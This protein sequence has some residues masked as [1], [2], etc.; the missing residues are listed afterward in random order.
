[1]FSAVQAFKALSDE[2]RL[3]LLNVLSR[4]ELN[5]NE[6]V[7]LMGMG[8]SRVSRHLKILSEAGLVGWRRD[9]LWIF[10]SAVRDG[11]G[12]DFTAAALPFVA[13]EEAF[14]ADLAL[15]AGIIEERTASTRHFFNRIAEDWDQLA[16]EVLGDFSLPEAVEKA[17]PACAV[18]ADL[19][20]GTGAVLERMLG[21]A[22]NV[23]GVDGSSR[24]LELARRRLSKDSGR[25]SLRIGDLGHL[26]LR[27]GEADF[28]SVNMVLHHLSDPVEALAEIRRVL[29]PGGKL[30]LSEFD[31][32]NDESMRN[33]YGDHW[34]GFS[35]ETLAGF[36]ERA[37][38][39]GLEMARRPVR[40]GLFIH[41]ILAANP[42]AKAE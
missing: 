10:Y 4:F 31:Q 30:M 6:L 9:G 39:A 14:K 1:M 16:E 36:L 11:S 13:S 8:Q 5:V 40:K 15:A 29:R 37:G 42:A 12:Q 38:F 41:L 22:K 24:M 25:I 32:H 26:P 27:D 18:A 2:T 20:C 34:L 33:A 21:K 23:I 17:M 35:R 3:R 7:E 28:T 19:G